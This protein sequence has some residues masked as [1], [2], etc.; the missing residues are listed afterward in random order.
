MNTVVVLQKL[1]E[2]ER[3]LDVVE[4][5]ATIRKMLVDAQLCVLELQRESPEQMRRDSRIV[6]RPESAQCS[7]E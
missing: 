2:I 7:V 3:A 6:C 1:N 4:E 5:R